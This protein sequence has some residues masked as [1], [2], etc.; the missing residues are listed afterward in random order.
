MA[1]IEFPPLDSA[2]ENGLIGVGG[3]LEAESLLLAY[4]NGIF[5]WPISKEYPIAWFSP[6]PRGII[7]TNDIHLPK[8]FKK[9]LKNHPYSVKFNTNFEAVILNCSRI[10][11]N[12]ETSTWI[13][14]DIINAYINFHK[15]GFAYSVEIYEADKLIG[16]L[17][18]VRIKNYVCGE[19]MF[20]T[21]DNASKL[22]LYSLILKLQNESISWLDTQMITPVVEQLGGY[23]ISRNKFMEY[24]NQSLK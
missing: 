12:H 15:L 9:F 19:S 3:D 10:K 23:Y 8:S 1:I 18:G 5:P 2:D 4:T 21:K 7:K 11:R 22:A 14:D 24:L 20:H 13:T 6:D 17:Y 16:G